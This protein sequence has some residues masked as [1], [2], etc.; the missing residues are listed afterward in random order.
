MRIASEGGH[1][2]VPAVIAGQRISETRRF[3]LHCSVPA[4][5]I[6]L[7]AAVSART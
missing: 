4:P 6:A 7:T 2:S 1:G 3:C 5:A